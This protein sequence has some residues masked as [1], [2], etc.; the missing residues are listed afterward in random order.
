MPRLLI[1][2]GSSAAREIQLKPGANS[3][4]RGSANDFQIED[5]SVSGSHCQIVVDHGQAFIK[6]LG[7]TNGTFVNRAPVREA[8]LQG[9]QTIH[10]GNVE[11]LFHGDAPVAVARLTH[12]RVVETELP[13]PPTMAPIAPAH[14]TATTFTTSQNCKFHPK[15]PGRWLCN[16]CQKFFCE[17]C[18]T[19]RMVGAV[20]HKYCRHCGTECTQ[21]QV[22]LARPAGAKGFFTRLPG[23]FIYPFKGSGL[24]I[25][26]IATV[27]FAVLDVISGG[28]AIFAKMAAVGYLFSYMQSIIH[29]TAAGDD[30]M[31]SLPGADELF[32]AFF[33]FA[34]T[35]TFC[36]GIPIGLAIAKFFFDVNIPGTALMVTMILCCL[37]FPMAF[38]AVAMKD[39][40]MAANPLVVMPAIF[41]VPAEYLVAS[42]L[43]TG[44][45]ILRLVGALMTM[46]A[47]GTGYATRDMSVLFISMGMRALWAFAS[48]YLL[49]VAM[50]ILGLLYVTKKHKLGWFSR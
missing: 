17:L 13:P 22:R 16:K 27:L 38:L 34:G 6:D 47:K 28:I 40:V 36:F 45:F 5:P 46:L 11:M 30:E 24:L 2:P 10:M 44:V 43:L 4:G 19:S 18:V 14:T 1:N 9:G 25:L 8:S 37:Y 12:P 35:V 42:V 15:V 39:T 33:T 32:G 3:L 50:R 31:A 29:C 7:S 23:V 26:I 48:I 49:T 20:Q 41:K 21:T